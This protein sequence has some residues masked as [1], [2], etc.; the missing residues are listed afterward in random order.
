MGRSAFPHEEPLLLTPQESELSK[1]R[2]KCES[3]E[4]EA[5]KKQRRCE[6][7]V[8]SKGFPEASRVV[9]S[10]SSAF[11]SCPVC[12]GGGLVRKGR[13]L[14]VGAGPP[15][16]SSPG[17]SG[18][19]AERSPERECPPCGGE[20]SAQWESHGKRAGSGSAHVL[21]G[22]ASA[23]ALV[24]GQGAVSAPPGPEYEGCYSPR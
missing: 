21:W 3:L 7:L 8:S 24:P 20:F 1:K 4:Q 22:W 17:F 6:E 10:L 11:T 18:T 19:A 12:G 9:G 13:I 5:R 2:K 15:P 14:F 16:Q 23:G